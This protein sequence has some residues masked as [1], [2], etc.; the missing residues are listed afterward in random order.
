MDRTELCRM[1]I[2]DG[3]IAGHDSCDGENGV[4]PQ[5]TVRFATVRDT[6]MERS[7]SRSS[8][9]EHED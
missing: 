6:R 9:N 1:S 4:A 5:L 8:M 3:A 2:G 7:R